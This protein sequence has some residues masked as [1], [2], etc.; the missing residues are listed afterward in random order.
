[1]RVFIALLAALLVFSAI[2]AAIVIAT[3]GDDSKTRTTTVV[4]TAR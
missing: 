2:G 4:E 3:D 1:M